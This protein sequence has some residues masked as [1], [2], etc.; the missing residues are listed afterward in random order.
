MKPPPGLSDSLSGIVESPTSCEV[1]GTALRL[2]QG[3]CV[4]CLLHEGLSDEM[5]G[6]EE[7]FAAVLAEA[8]IP[9]KQ[10]RLGN[11]DIQGEIGRGGMGIIYRARQRR[12]RRIVALKRVLTHHA[13]SHDSLQRFRR[14]AE[15]AAS[16]DHPNI[17]PIYEVSETEEGLPFFSMKLATGGS[18]REVGPSLRDDPNECVRLMA[19]VARAVAH[20]H[21]AGILHRDLQPGNILLD[22]RAEPM[23]SDFGLAK[24]IDESSNLTRTLTTFGTPGYIAPEQ[25]E[26]PAAAVTEAADIYSLGAILFGLLT[27]RPPFQGANALSVIRQ[28]AETT[29]PRLRS[30]AAGLDR[31][32]ETIVA[33]CLERD[34]G[35]R[36]ASAEALAEDL[37]RWLDGRPILAR[38]VSLPAQTWRWMRRDPTLAAAAAACLILAIALVSLLSGRRQVI[39]LDAPEKSI[40]VLPF[41]N[42]NHDEENGF[43]TAGIQ[44]D[45][46]TGLGKVADLKVISRSSVREYRPE[47]TRDLRAIAADLGVRHIV[48]GSVRRAEARVRITAQLTD[49]ATGAQLWAERYDRDLRDVFAIQSD[50]AQHIADQL[51]AHL[52]PSE[53]ATMR[54]KP[55]NDVVAYDLYLRAKEISEE[56]G[57]SSPDRMAKQISLLDQAIARDPAFVKALCLMARAH[58]RSYWSNYDHTP[59]RLDAA[60]RALD[61]AARVQ[62]NAGEVYLT[63]GILHYWGYRDYDPALAEL[64]LAAAALPNDGDVPYF[65][66]LI[67]RRQ[68]DWE[69]STRQLEHARKLDPRN[70]IMLFDLART[71]YF[72][73]KRYR[74]AA[75]TA[76]S[77]LAWK[78]DSFD[79]HLTRAKVDVASRADLARW[80]E[81]ARGETAKLSSEPQLLAYER[82]ELA[83]AERDYARAA[84]AL[85]NHT[86][87]EFS[88]AGYI[89]PHKW[90]E[91]LIAAALGDTASAQTSFE[92][93]R[94]RVAVAVS[95]RPADAKA[96]IVLAEIEA[97][98]GLKDEAIKRGEHALALRPVEKDAVDGPNI[99]GRLAC[100]YGRV[101]ELDRALNLL[102]EI[103]FVPGATNYGALKLDEIWDPL[104]GHPRFDAVVAALRAQAEGQN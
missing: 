39:P 27:G 46:L 41:E 58:L 4:N 52:S 42:L 8:K 25:A 84:E 66:G 40:A 98:M 38:R 88:W 69:R 67:T 1:C 15:A 9:D 21:A 100:I 37:Q 63:R 81:V 74:E 95:Q 68:G 53:Q 83:L 13:D 34:P 11:Y 2:G 22:A 72:S 49:A 3:T 65:I 71:N 101:G 48:E 20:A 92:A 16:L 45:I 64:E 59:T 56:P 61:A 5:A 17:L 82:I 96:Q 90:Y 75:E 14:E 32:L 77:V 19:K 102:E 29:A 36:Y 50:I 104:R 60:R 94:E 44:E 86:L 18:L 6:S 70:Q 7:V 30:V 55:T 26:G 12:S 78:P 97:R 10:W 51:K 57:I 89:T 76:D 28:A 47:A 99:M 91:G 35:A 93:A 54:A 85:A 31:D 43:F 87:P 80:R 23:V 62:P 73:L 33:R 79:F 103:A 24:W